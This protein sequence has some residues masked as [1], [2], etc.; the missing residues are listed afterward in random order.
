[1]GFYKNDNGNLLEALNFV[2][3]KDYTL[4]IENKETYTFPI[5][6]W[7]FF[8]SR[9]E[10]LAYFNIVEEPIEEPPLPLR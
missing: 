5:D 3:N 1:M 2:Y 8:N 10:A 6:N 7:Y 9:E 4:L